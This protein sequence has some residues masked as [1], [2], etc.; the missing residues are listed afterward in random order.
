MKIFKVFHGA[1][2]CC[3]YNNSMHGLTKNRALWNDDDEREKVYALHACLNLKKGSITQK[4]INCPSL[5]SH[6]LHN[7]VFYVHHNMC[8]NWWDP[9][10][11][12][13]WKIPLHA[14]SL[15]MV[16]SL[17][18]HSTSSFLSF[19]SSLNSV[20]KKCGRWEIFN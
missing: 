3:F 1:I 12:G 6:T 19:Q 4:N 7:Y 13:W 9:F 14:C 18:V 11:M 17:K 10:E 8:V 16:I 15:F 5:Y 20:R 2:C